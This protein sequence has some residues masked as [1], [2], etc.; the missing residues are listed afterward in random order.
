MFS[1]ALLRPQAPAPK[2]FSRTLFRPEL[3]ALED[4]AVPSAVWGSF[5]ENAQHT[6][7]TSIAAQTLQAVRWQQVVDQSPHYDDGDILAHYAAPLITQ[8][9]TVIIPERLSSGAWQ[10]Q[11]VSGASGAPMWT[12]TTNWVEPP[13]NWQLPYDPVLTSAGRLFYAGAGGTLYYIDNVDS[14]TPTAPVQVAFYGLANY[15]ADPSAY[16]A[17]VFITT[18]LTADANGDIYF[19]FSVTGTT[20]LG[21]QGGLARISFDPGTGLPVGISVSAATASGDA[22]MTKS[23]YNAAPALSNDGSTLYAAVNSGNGTS[24]FNTGY[25][26]VLN[27]TTL[28][29]E[30]SVLLKDPTTGNPAYLSDD[31]TASPLVGPDGD[32]YFGVL[33]DP[34]PH[35]DDRGFLLHFTGNLGTEKTPGDFGWD[36]TPSIVP[37]S[38]VPWY[39]PQAGSGTTYLIFSK[40][41]N[42]NDGG[43]PD[44]NGENQIAVLDPN[45]AATAVNGVP[46]MMKEVET[47][48][49][50]TA[51]PGGGVNEWCIN[52]A[53][54]DT[55]TDS[56]YAGSED[57]KLYCWNLDS[58]SFTQ[59]VTLTSGIGEAYTP[60]ALGPDGTVYAINNATLFA[61]GVDPHWVNWTDTG[62]AGTTLVVGTTA[63][64]TQELFTI[65]RDHALYEMEQNPDGSWG[66]WNWLGGGCA[67]PLA[68]ARNAAGY[69]DVYVIG[70]DGQLWYRDQTGPGTFAGWAGLGGYCAALAAGTNADGSEQVFVIGAGDN[71]LYTNLQVPG[72][73]TG[74][75]SLGG[76]CTT[77][78]AVARDASGYLDAYVI[79]RDGQLWYRDQ[80]SRDSFAGWAGLGGYCK[81]LAVGNNADGTAAVYVVGAG[82]NALYCNEQVPGGWTGW[83]SL[84]GGCAGPMAVVLD[85]EGY[86]TAFVVAEDGQVD[87]RVQ[88]ARGVFDGWSGLGGYAGAL[89]AGTNPDGTDAVFAS[90]LNTNE[91]WRRSPLS[92]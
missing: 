50:R 12:E 20:P 59:V 10:L 8:A 5:G 3:E 34:F 26:V 90:A 63:A 6:A 11:A 36:D 81:T 29:P 22:S 77:Q 66:A 53:V 17:N 51:N 72:G 86:L 75:Q 30:A 49:G 55:A 45:V 27:S 67:G 87:Y 91:L 56:V 9:N 24:S 41:N 78:L 42:Y 46:G 18:P 28:A 16:N 33:E 62:G 43:G 70:Q 61:V 57:G 82:D 76:G 1:R 21:L 88:T 83:Q 31:G 13:H 92:L 35:N 2:P 73:W 79:G 54:V 89:A 44:A 58:D 32:V 4:R 69:L 52:S 38:M 37:L 80:T 39:T 23:V 71:A 65:G 48:L 47:I 40:Y 14:S 60:T 68:V 7:V 19:G 25:L 84:G 85:S 15:Q 74:W 64:G